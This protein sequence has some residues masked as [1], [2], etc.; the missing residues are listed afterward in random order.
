M[1]SSLFLY[2][3][4]GSLIRMSLCLLHILKDQFFKFLGEIQLD[5]TNEKDYRTTRAHGRSE[6]DKVDPHL[7]QVCAQAPLYQLHA[8][9]S[10]LSSV[11]LVVYS[12]VF[13]FLF[14]FLLLSNL[15]NCS[16][17][18]KFQNKQMCSWNPTLNFAGEHIL[19]LLL[20]PK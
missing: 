2:L 4:K 18:K 10:N 16:A 6:Q 19:R 7:S 13:F 5:L 1:F 11:T 12:Q 15:Q 14:L 9:F 17:V 3:H 20:Q 8:V